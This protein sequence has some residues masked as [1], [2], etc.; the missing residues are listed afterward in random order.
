MTD[1]TGGAEIL[2]RRLFANAG[3]RAT[4]ASDGP[5]VMGIV[6]VTPDSFS[7]GGR[8]SGAGDAVA[9]GLRLIGE[10]AH[11]LDIGGE[12]TRPGAEPVPL[13]EELRRVVPVIEGLAARTDVPLSIDTR[14]AAVMR[15]AVGAGATLINDVSALAYDPASLKTAAGLGVPVVLMHAQGDPRT[16]QT[17]PRYDDVVDEVIRA[18]GARIAACN[19]AGIGRDRIIVDPGIGFGKTLAHNLALL[20]H[21]DQLHDLGCP[22]LLGA[23][24][25]SFIAKI[26]DGADADRRLAGSLMALDA[27]L[28]ARVAMVRVHDVFETVQAIAVRQAILRATEGR[29]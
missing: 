6:N 1:R 3:T 24:R 5:L 9:H 16:M 7:D 28:A 20:A 13:E 21:L 14:K 8:F 12:S 25:K 4:G 18:L 26:H 11:V 22:V 23:S 10:G 15:A 19:A 27:G 2:R 29:S 17:N